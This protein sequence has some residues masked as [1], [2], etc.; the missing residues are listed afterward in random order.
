MGGTTPSI[1]RTPLRARGFSSSSSVSRSFL[2]SSPV[3]RAAALAGTAARSARVRARALIRNER[4]TGT[5][6]AG[7]GPER[8]RG[9][10]ART[11]T[12]RAVTHRA[13]GSGRL[14]GPGTRRLAGAELVALT[15]HARAGTRRDAGAAGDTAGRGTAGRRVRNLRLRTFDRTRGRD[16][17]LAGGNRPK[18]RDRIGRSDGPADDRAGRRARSRH[19]GRARGGRSGGRTIAAGRLGDGRRGRGRDARRRSGGR[20]DGCY[21][22][23]F[24]SRRCDGR[25]GY[26]RADGS[27]RFRSGLGDAAGRGGHRP[28]AAARARRWR[29]EPPG[30]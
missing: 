21:R 11:R 17:R 1:R 2:D 5:A 16:R 4:H 12:E 3:G 15:G 27:G 19:R 10:A 25:L 24:G 26:R 28:S 7:A 6:A 14:G 18:L 8:A 13:G 9:R 22:R 23:S 30:A 29:R 20:T